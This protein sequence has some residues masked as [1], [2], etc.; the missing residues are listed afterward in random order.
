MIYV[1]E[2]TAKLL[3]VNMKTNITYSGYILGMFPNYSVSLNPRL[4][5]IMS[6]YIIV[7]RCTLIVYKQYT[8][9]KSKYEYA[10]FPSTNTRTAR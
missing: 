8:R 2:Q 5:T 1:T 4:N 9:D 6:I 7:R 10:G 3:F